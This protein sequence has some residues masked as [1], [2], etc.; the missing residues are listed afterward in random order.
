MNVTGIIHWRAC[1][2]SQDGLHRRIAAASSA[3]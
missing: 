3:V 1:S 2:F